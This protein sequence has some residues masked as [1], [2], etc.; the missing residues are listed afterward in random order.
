MGTL[1]GS[2]G[3]GKEGVLRSLCVAGVSGQLAAIY[4]AFLPLDIVNAHVDCAGSQNVGARG[5]CLS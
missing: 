5:R 3:K 4:S 1:R 2:Y